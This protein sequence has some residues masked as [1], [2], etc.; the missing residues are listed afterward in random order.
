[1]D[2]EEIRWHT[3]EY[4]PTTR[5]TDWFWGFGLIVIVGMALAIWFGN[6][7]FA[8]IILLSAA[9]IGMLSLRD[10][11]EIDCRLTERGVSVGDDFY[12]YRSIESFSIHDRH[13]E[14]KLVLCLKKF[15]VPHLSVPLGQTN[16]KEVQLYLSEHLPEEERHS[17]IA[18]SIARRLGF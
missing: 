17:A 3:L 13:D 7:L 18:D 16:P 8:V 10:P 6:G 4:S 15:M 5:S 1:M 9:L 14:H 11:R 12:P 2:R